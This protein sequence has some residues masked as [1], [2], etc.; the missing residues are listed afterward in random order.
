MKKYNYENI[1]D[2]LYN[3]VDIIDFYKDEKIVK[4]DKVL[5][6]NSCLSNE[7]INLLCVLGFPKTVGPGLSFSNSEVS[8]F[9][10]YK[11]SKNINIIKD[12]ICL[13]EDSWGDYLCLNIKNNEIKLFSHE[14]EIYKENFYIKV[15]NSVKQFFESILRFK[16][17]VKEIKENVD[18]NLILE[19]KIP[20]NFIK[21]LRDDL[22][23]IDYDIFKEKNSFWNIQIDMIENSLCSKK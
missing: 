10:R 11:V 8:L 17:Y 21:S 7:E 3:G 13:G 9:S 1:I 4:Y 22:R 23:D 6:N 16:L 2:N 15:N 5:F 19:D 12:N 14:L 20:I 18:I